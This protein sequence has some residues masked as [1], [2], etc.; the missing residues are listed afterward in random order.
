MRAQVL[1]PLMRKTRTSPRRRA[2]RRNDLEDYFCESDHS[3]HDDTG[4]SEYVASKASKHAAKVENNAVILYGPLGIGKTAAVYA[5]AHQLGYDVLGTS[6]KAIL[7][8]HLHS[9]SCHN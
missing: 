1:E 8:L 5:C 4:D 9:H 6:L 2:K 3:E 7:L